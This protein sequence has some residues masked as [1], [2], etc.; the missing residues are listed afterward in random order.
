MQILRQFDAFPKTLDDVRVRTGAGAVVS[1][2]GFIM[3]VYLFVAEFNNYRTVRTDSS[4]YVDMSIGEKL[5]INFDVTFPAFPCE[6]LHLD[7]MDIS[8]YQQLELDHNVFKQRLDPDGRAHHPKSQINVGEDGDVTA[9]LENKTAEDSCGSCYGAGEE[10]ECCNTCEDVRVAYRKKG[11]SFEQANADGSMVQCAHDNYIENLNEQAEGNEG[12]NLHGS[13]EVQKVA[14][15]FH[16]GVGRN[17]QMASMH[18]HDLMPLRNININL[19]HTINHMSFG[20]GERTCI[21]N[22][23]AL[24]L[25]VFYWPHGADTAVCVRARVCV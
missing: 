13:I 24:R 15:N 1:F 16:F 23:T 4:M 9:A 7:A 5:I 2:C 17:F 3:I 14:G 20:T 8:G 18:V 12:C 21:A 25:S 10:G 22:Y 11:W 6:A 19:T